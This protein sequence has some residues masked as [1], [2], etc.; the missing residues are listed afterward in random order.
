LGRRLLIQT[1]FPDRSGDVA[2]A[3]KFRFEIGE[4]G[5]L[6]YVLRPGIWKR[7]GISQF[8]FQKFLCRWSGYIV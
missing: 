1:C 3:T 8:Q 7:S 6:T 5:V 2:T 4:I